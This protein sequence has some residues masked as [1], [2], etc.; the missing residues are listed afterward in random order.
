M[1]ACWNGPVPPPCSAATTKSTFCWWM[2]LAPRPRES[3]RDRC[4]RRA[5]D[6]L[7]LPL[8]LGRQA[9]TPILWERLDRDSATGPS[10]PVEGS[11]S[12][13]FLSGL[14]RPRRE[15][16]RDRRAAEQR[17]ELAASDESCHLIPPAGRLRPNDSTVERSGGV[18]RVLPVS[19]C[20]AYLGPH[21]AASA[22]PAGRVRPALPTDES[23]EAALRRAVAA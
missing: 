19:V 3:G 15:R 18:L 13:G 6:Q 21:A 8:A 9:L 17:D 16:P 14:L 5:R 1:L 22:Y 12:A 20:L 11:Q 2:S 4:R 7:D 10:G 23:A